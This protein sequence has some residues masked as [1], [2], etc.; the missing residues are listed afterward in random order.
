MTVGIQ[1]LYPH[2]HHAQRHQSDINILLYH[3]YY[4]TIMKRHLQTT[5]LSSNPRQWLRSNQAAK[6]LIRR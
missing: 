4:R 2:P 6:I 1:L 5:Q 3:P